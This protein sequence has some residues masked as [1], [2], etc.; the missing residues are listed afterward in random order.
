MTMTGPGNSA[1]T[2]FSSLGHRRQSSLAIILRRHHYR[3]PYL[4]TTPAL[5]TAAAV[6]QPHRATVLHSKLTIRSQVVVCMT[7]RAIL[8]RQ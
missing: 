8:V 5:S 4:L 1:S 7:A 3:Q 2:G 6:R